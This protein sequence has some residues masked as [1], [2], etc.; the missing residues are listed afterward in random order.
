MLSRRLISATL[1][2]LYI[3][4]VGYLCF[5][6]PEDIPQLPDLWF[7]LPADKVG[8]FLMFVPFPLLGFMVFDKEDTG[9][10]RRIMLLGI[11]II[12]GFGMAAGTESIQA[13]MASRSAEMKDLL[14]DSA[15]LAAGAIL[16]VS[17][18]F[19]GRK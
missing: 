14:A 9:I 8:H 1:F 15:G 13:S 16:T 19:I 3:A 5:A 10:A 11:M 7:G 12:C 2:C 18:I 17:Y 4:A 6:K